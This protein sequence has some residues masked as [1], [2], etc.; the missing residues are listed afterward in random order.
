MWHNDVWGRLQDR[1]GLNKSPNKAKPGDKFIVPG[2]KPT[3]IPEGHVLLKRIPRTNF[4]QV[5]YRDGSFENLVYSKTTEDFLVRK[6]GC[7]PFK[8]D[9][10]T[11]FL[12]NFNKVIVP[13]RTPEERD[14]NPWTQYD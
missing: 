4:L 13:I 8:V 12:F 7:N 11:N 3:P 14:W 10:Y 5:H 2:P 6:V 1:L 9:W